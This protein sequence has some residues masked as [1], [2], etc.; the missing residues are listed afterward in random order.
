MTQSRIAETLFVVVVSLLGVSECWN[1]E[2]PDNLYSV[3]GETLE[4]FELTT[5]N[6]FVS[7]QNTQEG[8]EIYVVYLV[9]EE[10]VTLVVKANKNRDTEKLENGDGAIFV[11]PGFYHLV[12]T[13]DI[14]DEAIDFQDIVDLYDSLNGLGKLGTVTPYMNLPW[15]NFE[16][17]PP[18]LVGET[19]G[20]NKSVLNNMSLKLF[21]DVE[22]A[23]Q[24]IRPIDVVHKEDKVLVEDYKKYLVVNGDNVLRRYMQ[25]YIMPRRQAAYESKSGGKASHTGIAKVTKAVVDKFTE[26]IKGAVDS[27]LRITMAG[28]YKD[29]MIPMFNKEGVQTFLKTKEVVFEK[30]LILYTARK[31]FPNGISQNL[32]VNL[33][34]APSSQPGQVF[35][36]GEAMVTETLAFYR[37]YALTQIQEQI[38]DILQ[39]QYTVEFLKNVREKTEQAV[40]HINTNMLQATYKTEFQDNEKQSLVDTLFKSFSVVDF[41][42]DLMI[43]A[44]TPAIRTFVHNYIWYTANYT[45]FGELTLFQA[46]EITQFGSK[47][48]LV[49][50]K[51][52]YSFLAPMSGMNQVPFNRVADFTFL[53]Q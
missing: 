22:T 41:L 45:M 48:N 11:T 10:P 17:W 30:N 6:F 25:T 28:F 1:F 3:E 52:A 29:T 49:L 42:L 47:A 13:S 50:N 32:N 16:S 35:A 5:D 21:P 44:V 33:S 23:D 18:L 12:G 2:S 40:E 7:T 4:K 15:Y 9:S 31:M 19:I 26:L 20:N 51:L 38:T 34:V 37:S 43:E 8:K 39:N 53:T 14:V 27:S 24:F 36:L 46:G